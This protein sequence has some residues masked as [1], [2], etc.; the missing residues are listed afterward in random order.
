MA[1]DK[2]G[3]QGGGTGGEGDPN[4]ET[5]DKLTPAEHIT[6]LNH[7]S[8][9]HRRD[10]KEA[11]ENAARLETALN[12]ANE[13]IA[14]LKESG[15]AGKTAKERLALLETG[16][17]KSAVRDEVR[18]QIAKK[19][20]AAKEA[21]MSVNTGAIDGLMNSLAININYTDD[22]IMD[23]DGASAIVRSAAQ[24]HIAGVVGNLITAVSQKTEVVSEV[25]PTGQTVVDR[26]KTPLSKLFE[27]GQPNSWDVPSPLAP[28]ERGK[29]KV[30]AA[31]AEDDT[32]AL[33]GQVFGR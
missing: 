26:S 28:G 17:K 20:A 11:K 7:E 33:L 9:E 18:A 22:V 15:T 21:G 4:A 16:I 24:E 32:Q 1:E 5:G 29:K 6:K 31:M 14:E 30:A 12:K 23:T 25:T 3:T 10:A 2:S 8:A 13:A 27:G 19:L